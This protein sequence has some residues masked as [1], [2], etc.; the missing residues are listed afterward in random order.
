MVTTGIVR[1]I[2]NLGR[3]VLPK[4]LRYSLSI[5]SGDDFEILI[6]GDKIILKRY[7][8]IKENKDNIL[9]LLDNVNKNINFKI[10][11]IVNNKFINNDYIIDDEL[12]LLINERKIYKNEILVKK[13]LKNDL[14]NVVY[15]VIMNSDLLCTLIAFGNENTDYIENILK[16]VVALIKD[17]IN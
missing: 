15:P 7:S 16:L 9:K 12:K 4:E 10:L 13:L 6:D 14:N 8:K 17:L 2:D 5:N 11:L 1:K 3:I